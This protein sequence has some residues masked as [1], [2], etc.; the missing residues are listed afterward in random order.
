MK[1]G[2]RIHYQR[3]QRNLNDLWLTLFAAVGQP[4]ST[5][6]DEQFCQGPISEL[7]V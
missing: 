1:S 3:E 4:R 7:L 6:G 2:Q 5:F